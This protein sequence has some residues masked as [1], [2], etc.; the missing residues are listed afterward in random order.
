MTGWLL[1]EFLAVRDVEECQPRRV[2]TVV[3]DCKRESSARFVPS[4]WAA[5]RS[6][7]AKGRHRDSFVR[8]W[9]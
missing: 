1:A 8:L 3:S 9:Q 7:I 4:S 2:V 6:L 5:I